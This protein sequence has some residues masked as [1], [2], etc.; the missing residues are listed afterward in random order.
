MPWESL[1]NNFL[2]LWQFHGLLEQETTEITEMIP[3]LSLSALFPNGANIAFAVRASRW[4][5]S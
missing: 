2:I 5:F 4:N 1:T 3:L